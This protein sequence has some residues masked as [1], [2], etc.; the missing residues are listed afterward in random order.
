MNTEL[1][2]L[3]QKDIKTCHLYFVAHEC[4]LDHSRHHAHKLVHVQVGMQTH[5]E[6]RLVGLTGINFVLLFTTVSWKRNIGQ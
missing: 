3:T 1:K 4:R 5:R 2:F 6:R